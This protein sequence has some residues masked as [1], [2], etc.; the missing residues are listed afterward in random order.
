MARCSPHATNSRHGAGSW[1]SRGTRRASSSSCTPGCLACAAFR[2][3]PGSSC[4][5][6]RSPG[7]PCTGPQPPGIP[8]RQGL[9]KKAG[10]LGAAVPAPHEYACGSARDS[11][12][13]LLRGPTARGLVCICSVLALSPHGLDQDLKGGG[14]DARRC[15][16]PWDLLPCTRRC[17]SHLLASLYMHAPTMQL[18]SICTHPLFSSQRC[19]T[20][21]VWPAAKLLDVGDWVGGKHG[22]LHYGHCH[23]LS[24][25]PAGA[26]RVRGVVARAR[27]LPGGTAGPRGLLGVGRAGR[28]GSAASA[29]A[30]RSCT[31]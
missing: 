16:D 23:G 14:R 30:G 12:A 13:R 2:R 19:A 27:A 26:P 21:L 5:R 4:T 29:A 8:R 11:G 7:C 15:G 9:L 18:L 17:P 6:S 3:R 28:W 24:Q 1:P 31:C 10:G 25:V 20:H 22:R